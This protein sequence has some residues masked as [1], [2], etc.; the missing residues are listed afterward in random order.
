V[1]WGKAEMATGEPRIYMGLRDSFL[2]AIQSYHWKMTQE[3]G[4]MERLMI[5]GSEM[6]LEKTSQG[7]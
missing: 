2:Y 7:L 4:V 1:Y 6:L 5:A 3:K